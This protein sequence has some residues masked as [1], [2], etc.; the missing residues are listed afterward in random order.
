MTAKICTTRTRTKLHKEMELIK[1]LIKESDLL[2]T[3]YVNME[4]LEK[5]LW[6]GD[7]EL[8]IMADKWLL[9]DLIVW[10]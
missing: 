3:Q 8:K 1:P 6:Q 9:S 2:L 10:C 5:N 4:E 7:E